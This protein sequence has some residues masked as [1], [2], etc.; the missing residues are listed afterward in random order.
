MLN[1]KCDFYSS[2]WYGG[3]FSSL[4]KL[5]PLNSEVIPMEIFSNMS[6]DIRS[7][8]MAMWLYRGALQT[9]HV[10]PLIQGTKDQTAVK[11]LITKVTY[12]YSSVDPFY[13]QAVLKEALKETWMLTYN[14]VQFP[15]K[16]TLNEV[17][18]Y[19]PFPS[20]QLQGQGI[21]TNQ[22]YIF[23]PSYIFYTGITKTLREYLSPLYLFPVENFKTGVFLSQ[24]FFCEQIDLV[25]EEYDFHFTTTFFKV[26]HKTI[27][28]ASFRNVNIDM[29]KS[30]SS[31]VVE[32]L[33][34]RVCIDEF[35]D[36]SNKRENS[37]RILWSYNLI[38]FV[39][40]YHLV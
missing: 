24:L 27:Y 36:N 23:I 3:P 6:V 35:F 29:Y 16:A 4:L 10:L 38:L 12:P 30:Q 15:L 31:P 22:P 14:G 37:C 34:V 32:S 28:D 25:P 13:L 11:Y 2:Q 39:L 5:T 18:D 26:T 20:R 21:N 1:N 40:F 8:N 7:N 17:L 9:W 19:T 33:T